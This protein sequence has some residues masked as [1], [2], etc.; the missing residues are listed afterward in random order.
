MDT[1]HISAPHL[2]D[3]AY[4]SMIQKKAEDLMT[5]WYKLLYP[6]TPHMDAVRLA[7]LKSLEEQRAINNEIMPAEPMTRTERNKQLSDI[8]D[9]IRHNEWKA[10][11]HDQ[12]PANAV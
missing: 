5:E 1:P 8:E 4:H 2:R 3:M 7:A 12:T 9:C 6:F 10:I 11:T